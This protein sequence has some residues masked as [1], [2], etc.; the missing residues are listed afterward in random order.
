[1]TKVSELAGTPWHVE[2]LTRNKGDERRHKSRCIYYRKKDSYCKYQ[3]IKCI[4][5]RYCQYYKAKVVKEDNKN[6]DVAISKKEV[7]DKLTDAEGMRLY[8]VGTKVYH[9]KFGEGF[10]TAIK[11]GHIVID[12]EDVGEKILGLNVCVAKEYLEIIQTPVI[13]EKEAIEVCKENVA[14]DDKIDHHQRAEQSIE[15]KSIWEWLGKL[16]SNLFRRE[17]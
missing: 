7:K 2:K 6:T 13:S 16:L 1:M 3:Y 14:N 8:P 5:S 12:F 15:K 10:I 9:Q 4:G 11:D 17:K